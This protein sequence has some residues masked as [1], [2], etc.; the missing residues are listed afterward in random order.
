MGEGR[1]RKQERQPK[2]STK[3]IHL[4]WIQKSQVAATVSQHTLWLKSEQ[5]EAAAQDMGAL[6][7]TQSKIKWKC[8]SLIEEK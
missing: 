5:G 3:S 8:P 7:H 6:S 1:P 4:A 2:N